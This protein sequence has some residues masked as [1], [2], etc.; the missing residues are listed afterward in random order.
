MMMIIE[1]SEIQRIK[2][3]ITQ[4]RLYV[5]MNPPI[6]PISTANYVAISAV[7]IL[8]ESAAQQN[9]IANEFLE[10]KINWLN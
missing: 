1:R 2:E 7:S 10:A 8:V 6:M 4:W 9:F 3:T 5:V